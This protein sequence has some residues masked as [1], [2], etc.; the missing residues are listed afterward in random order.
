MKKSIVAALALSLV[1][2]GL[3]SPASAA[4][5]KKKPKPP[6]VGPAPVQEDVTYFLR[7]TSCGEDT[8][9]T[10]L[11]ITDGPDEGDDCGS[12]ESGLL[13]ELFLETGQDPPA[14]PMVADLGPDQTTFTGEDGIPFVLDATK[15]VRGSIALGSFCCGGPG[16][17]AGQ[18]TLHAVLT[19]TVNGEAKTI[20]E[21]STTYVVSP[22]T[23]PTIVEFEIK[24]DAALDK[25]S[26]TTLELQLTNRG[27][28]YLNGFYSY[29]DPSSQI[30]VGT[31]K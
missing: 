21:A 11:S 24:P 17:S 1:A 3:L 22:A 7:R 15:P 19:G 29:D 27:V 14:I 31:W 16:I 9:K 28:S 13:T 26:F 12:L 18:A 10:T 23:E 6:V 2:A 20:G 8:D 25:L 5:K 30:I 4:K